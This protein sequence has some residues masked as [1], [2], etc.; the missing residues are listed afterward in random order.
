VAVIEAIIR[1]ERGGVVKPVN[2]EAGDSVASD[3]MLVEFE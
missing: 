1:A 2:A 3:E